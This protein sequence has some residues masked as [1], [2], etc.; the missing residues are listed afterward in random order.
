MAAPPPAPHP[1]CSSVGPPRAACDPQALAW[2][3]R[4]CGTLFRARD[5]EE[6]LCPASSCRPPRRPWGLGPGEGPGLATCPRPA[7]ICHLE[8]PRRPPPQDAQPCS[9]AQ[10][11][12]AP[13]CGTRRGTSREP[14]SCVRW[15]RM[16]AAHL[17]ATGGAQ[18]RGA[19]R[20]DRAPN[21]NPLP[22]PPPP[23][24]ASVRWAPS[25]APCLPG[26]RGGGAG[27][28]SRSLGPGGEVQCKGPRVRHQLAAPESA[29]EPTAEAS[30]PPECP[31]GPSAG[32]APS[33]PSSR[34]SPTVQPPGPE[35]GLS[36]G[37]CC[38]SHVTP[39][40]E[41]QGAG[42]A[43]LQGGGARRPLAPRAGRG[44]GRA[45]AGW[46][47]PLP[48][49]P[50]CHHG[51]MATL[52]PTH[53]RASA[54]QATVPL[55]R[56]EVDGQETDIP[57]RWPGRLAGPPAR[58][59]GG[60]AVRVAQGLREGPPP[61]CSPSS[62]SAPPAAPARLLPGSSGTGP[63]LP[64]V[65]GGPQAAHPPPG[66]WADPRRTSLAGTAAGGPSACP[67]PA[68][69][70]AGIQP[71]WPEDLGQGDSQLGPGGDWTGSSVV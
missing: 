14:S 69:I 51:D 64:A 7:P 30:Q 57:R 70:R 10:P 4:Q 20:Q 52:P 66:P 23:C 8:R 49:G 71:S 15:P 35:G 60:Q 27:R 61:L 42:G 46:P 41:P 39:R 50:S 22:R 43:G 26:P 44:S 25:A 33:A 9:L 59:G 47:A 17:Q 31:A 28:D 21:P 63:R 45:G 6:A 13:E 11:Q 29:R 65:P 56:L 24:A 36:R 55:V 12:A 1:A 3:A 2:V 53:S 40:G 37:G 18:V 34:C 62:P 48:S 38:W 67:I 32:A 58:R 5:R 54:R 19:Q 68:L 16:A